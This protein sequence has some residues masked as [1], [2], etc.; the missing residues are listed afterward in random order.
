M[1]SDPLT[2]GVKRCCDC[3]VE[4]AVNCFSK[5]QSQ[6]K[7]CQSKRKRGWVEQL[8][9]DLLRHYGDRCTCCQEDFPHFLVIDHVSMAGGAERKRAGGSI[10][11]W[12]SVRESGFPPGYRTLCAS[13]NM[14]AARI[15]NNLDVIHNARLRNALFIVAPSSPVRQYNPAHTEGKQCKK[16]KQVKPTPDF[17]V[18]PRKAGGIRSTCKSCS[19]HSR[20]RHREWERLE[21]LNHYGARCCG[22]ASEFVPELTIDHIGGMTGKKR[23]SQAMLYDSII[24]GGFPL[25][26]RVLCMNCNLAICRFGNDLDMLQTAITEW[27][28][29]TQTSTLI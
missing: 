18:D 13:C 6:C 27:R 28:S 12:A 17:V 11:V 25:S 8:R 2:P 7:P 23:V 16:C 3:K 22:C 9:S 1:R 24:Q 4:R 19:S 15:G 10:A 29:R 20:R 14:M 21:V 26:I 5:S